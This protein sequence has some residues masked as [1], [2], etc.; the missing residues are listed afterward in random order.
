MPGKLSTNLMLGHLGKT[1]ITHIK[2]KTNWNKLWSLIP[3]QLKLTIQT[4]DPNHGL[5]RVHHFFY[6]VYQIIWQNYKFFQKSR[7]N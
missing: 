6:N 1:L 5:N 3:N 4:R 2:H 7:T